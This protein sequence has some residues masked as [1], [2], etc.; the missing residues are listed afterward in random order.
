M[1]LLIFMVYV[2]VVVNNCVK[3][4]L[5]LDY[6]KLQDFFDVPHQLAIV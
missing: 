5:Q 3:Y 6:A 4:R 2:M 1:H